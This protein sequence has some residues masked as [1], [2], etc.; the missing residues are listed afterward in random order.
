M[1]VPEGIPLMLV[2][3]GI[4]VFLVLFVACIVLSIGVKETMIRVGLI[5]AAVLLAVVMGGGA[6]LTMTGGEEDEKEKDPPAVEESV[7]PP[8][9]PSSSS[10]PAALVRSP[11]KNTSA[12]PS[13]VM[14]KRNWVPAR[15]QRKSE[16]INGPPL[17][18]VLYQYKRRTCQ[19]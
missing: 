6:Y 7:T 5:I 10:C 8:E 13:E 11:Q 1:A 17:F 3:T 14:Q 19:V 18:P 15:A 16:F 12:A 4:F 9:K 2:F